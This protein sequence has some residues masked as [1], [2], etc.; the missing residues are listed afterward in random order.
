MADIKI[1][2][3]NTP[4]KNSEAVEGK[5]YHTIYGGATLAKKPTPKTALRDDTG[6]NISIK[7]RSYCEVTV[8]YWA[9]K[10]VQADYYGFCHYRRY[11]GFSAQ[12]DSAD[13]YGNIV[14]DFINERTIDQYGLD[15]KTAHKVIASSDIVVTSRVDVLKMPE[16]YS[17]IREHYRK[18]CSLHE[19]DIDILLDIIAKV[20]PEYCQ[21]AQDYFLGHTGYFCNMFIM[22]RELFQIYAQWLFKIL[23]EF[24]KRAD[25]AHYSIEGYRTTGHLAERL[26][27]IFIDYQVKN[28]PGIIVREVPCVLFRYPE[29][30]SLICKPSKENCVPIVF[31]ANNAFVGPL[32]VAVKSVLNHASQTRFYDIVVLE[33]DITVQ[34]KKILSEMVSH[35]PNAQLRYYN[36]RSKL[37]G[38]KL[39]AHA[40]ISVETFYRFLIQSIMPEYDKVLYLDGDIVACADVAELYDKDIQD[41]MLAAA[42]DIDFASQINGFAPGMMKYA[43]K[44][45]K[46]KNPYGY[47]QAGVLLLNLDEMRKVHTQ[48]EWLELASVDYKYSDQDV[49]NICCEGKVSYLEQEWNLVFDNDFSRVRDVLRYAPRELRHAYDKAALKPK[50]VH[51]AG[52]AKPWNQLP[53][54]R[55]D[56]F[57]GVARETPFYECMLYQMNIALGRLMA[58]QTVQ[59]H[60]GEYHTGFLTK[61]IRKIK[62]I[63]HK[64]VNSLIPKGTV[65]RMKIKNYMKIGEEQHEEYLWEESYR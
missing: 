31:A 53:A 9:W 7:N 51:F 4:G 12:N 25:M 47:F 35:Y 54:D 19:R 14:D 10:N 48:E 34:N 38:Y 61:V 37:D 28:T 56:L 1:F 18:A 39:I 16:C 57:W 20:S 17:S 43:V 21:T 60:L 22:R 32:S 13:V 5:L 6:D 3:C 45:L 23:D 41:K 33:S 24:E 58:Y 29:K 36:A 15:E 65:R 50:I 59:T 40:H 30:Q 62:R 11:F 63:P 27:G 44:K 46:L 55:F 52:H 8:Q 64:I 26:C 42:L 2:V 49:L